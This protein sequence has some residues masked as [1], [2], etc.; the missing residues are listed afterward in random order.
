[1][2]GLVR[3]FPGLRNH[4]KLRRIMYCI[5]IC[6]G[7]L[8]IITPTFLIYV[9]EISTATPFVPSPKPEESQFIN[10][11]GRVGEVNPNG[12]N[13]HLLL[14]LQ[15]GINQK[16][17]KLFLVLPSSEV[18]L[19]KGIVFYAGGRAFEFHSGERLGPSMFN[20]TQLML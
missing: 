3:V 13:F 11:T 7:W 4:A 19:V 6:L 2:L 5:L 17:E 15:A 14:D 12:G 20:L 8:L 1:M 18:Q 16:D 10:V 9:K